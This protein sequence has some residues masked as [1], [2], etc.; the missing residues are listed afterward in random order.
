MLAPVQHGAQFRAARPAPSA[1]RPARNLSPGDTHALPEQAGHW[2]PE[3]AEAWEEVHAA[4]LCPLSAL[5]HLL[6]L[7]G[8]VLHWKFCPQRENRVS[9]RS[10][11][12]LCPLITIFS[13]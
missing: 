12:P 3:Q 13:A 5:A 7:P 9:E 6:H 2:L 11:T 1:P 10:L 8:C 4:C